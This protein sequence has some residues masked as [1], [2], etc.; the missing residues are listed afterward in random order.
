MVKINGKDYDVSGMTITE[1]LTST[2]Y[3]KELIALER[4][5]EIVPKAE[6]DN[7]VIEDGDIIEIVSFVGGGS[8]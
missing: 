6:Y 7:T 8:L 1:Y 5:E 2:E 3:K 4:N